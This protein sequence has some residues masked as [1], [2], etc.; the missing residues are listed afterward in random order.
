MVVLQAGMEFCNLKPHLGSQ[1]MRRGSRAARRTGRPFGSRTIARPM[2]TRCLCPPESA[3][4][5][6]S[7]KWMSCKVSA[8]ARTFASISD[9]GTAGKRKSEADIFRNRHMRIKRIALE[10]HRDTALRWFGVRDILARL[11]SA[12][13]TSTSSSPAMIRSKRG[14]SASGRP[15]KYDE[16]TRNAPPG[17]CP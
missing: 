12:C 15:D 3:F 17:R 9:F 8:A 6:R 2:A 14:F 11:S 4:G 13:R 5:L 1:T 7:S 16:F 10:H